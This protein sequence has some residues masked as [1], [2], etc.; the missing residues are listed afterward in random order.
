MFVNING[1]TVKITDKINSKTHPH[2]FANVKEI[3]TPA[4]KFSA[5]MFSI[6][7]RAKIK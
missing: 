2:V 1:Q 5:Q 7:T 6:E 3:L 4:E